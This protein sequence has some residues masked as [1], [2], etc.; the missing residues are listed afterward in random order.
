MIICFR[1]TTTPPPHA[2][3]R[4]VT[5]TWYVHDKSL[6]SPTQAGLV[7]GLT[8]GKSTVGLHTSPG[9]RMYTFHKPHSCSTEVCTVW[10][11]RIPSPYRIR[12]QRNCYSIHP[13]LHPIPFSQP[14]DSAMPRN[15]M[16]IFRWRTPT[17]GLCLLA[18]PYTCSTTH[19]RKR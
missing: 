11:R 3:V 14:I 19:K 9:P 17:S 8:C 10:I 15:G 7:I 4:V 1:R 16:A 18:C 2:Q 13:F 6:V 12:L 5:C